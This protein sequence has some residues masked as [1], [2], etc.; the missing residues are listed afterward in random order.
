MSTEH[1]KY[2]TANQS[3]IIVEYAAKRGFEI[4]KTYADD[5]KSGLSVSGRVPGPWN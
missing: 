4:V 5:G 3:D 2:S 1:Q